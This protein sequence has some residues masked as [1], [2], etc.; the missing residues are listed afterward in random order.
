M[1][2]FSPDDIFSDQSPID[3]GFM[4]E[5]IR[6]VIQS[7]PLSGPEPAA[8]IQRRMHCALIML[9]ALY[10]RDETEVAL[11]VQAVSAYHA[12]ASCWH[13]AMNLPADQLAERHRHRAAAGSSA[14]TFDTLLKSLERRQA[15]PLTVPPGR[16]E[17]R[18]WGPMQTQPFIE[19]LESRVAQED[20][21][22]PLLPAH[23]SKE[24]IAA[25]EAISEQHRFGDDNAGL[26]LA[27][28]DGILPGGG[29]IVP[30]NPTPQQAAYLARRLRLMYQREHR[31]NLR[32]GVKTPIRI[33]GFRTGDLIP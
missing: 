21:R 26:D 33:R 29:M 2:D 23:W 13:W 17:P 10:P 5:A 8:W 32:N 14:R 1:P 15:K 4:D 30:E 12:A 11:A 31:E 7:L 18:T 16:P 19:R 20:D 27:N 6:N 22:P 9:A 25:A 24:A 28:T 3:P